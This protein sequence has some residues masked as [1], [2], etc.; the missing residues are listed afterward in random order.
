MLDRPRPALEFE[1]RA[2]EWLPGSS[3]RIPRDMLTYVVGL[4]DLGKT[5]WGHRL[6]ANA[7]RAGLNVIFSNIE[8]GP[9]QVTRP[10]LEAAGAILERV[11]LFTPH[12]FPRI[13]DELDLLRAYVRAV[14]LVI[15]D[16]LSPHLTVAVRNGQAVRRALDPV[17]ELALETHTTVVGIGHG[18]KSIK[19][20]SSPL[21]I[22]P[23]PH[24]GIA[25]ASHAIYLFGHHPENADERVLVNLR[26]KVAEQPKTMAFEID[27]A[28]VQTSDGSILEAP[29][30]HDVADDLSVDWWAA[31]QASRRQAGPPVSKVEAAA[32]WLTDVLAAAEPN[33]IESGNLKL[34]AANAG[35]SWRTVRRAA[36]DLELEIVPPKGP[37]THSLW[38]LPED[39]P[40]RSSGT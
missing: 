2:V 26:L 28:E 14:D 7:T 16:P 11:G 18:I 21:D 30:L 33:P 29:F 39:H 8:D 40:L 5:L 19:S 4:P 31:V 9:E 27:T 38:R 34:E 1:P 37:G 13:P 10:R 32:Q 23:G 17:V 15:L 25:G 20:K 35:I 3:G 12:S 36:K 22:V 24:E 6:T